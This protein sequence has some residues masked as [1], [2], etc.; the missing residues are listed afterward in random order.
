MKR[1]CM[2]CGEEMGEIAGG[3]VKGISHSICDECLVAPKAVEKNEF[4]HMCSTCASEKM[5][6][7]C[8]F[9]QMDAEKEELWLCLECGVGTVLLPQGRKNSAFGFCR[10][11]TR[12]THK[13]C[14][15]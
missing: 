12:H 14:C 3:G 8:S 5:I 2:Y 13:F 4:F 9:G 11:Y 6:F 1:I 7:I 15:G 10:A